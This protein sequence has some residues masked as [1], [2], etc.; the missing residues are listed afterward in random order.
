MS[1]GSKRRLSQ[2]VGLVLL[3][4]GTA[5]LIYEP[6]RMRA[7]WPSV[8]ALALV[9]LTRRA[10]LG[11]LV[12]AVVG[13]LLLAGGNPVGAVT[14]LGRDHLAP[15][16][17]SEWKLAAIAFTLILGGFAG[18][19]ERGGGLEGL[20]NGA[21]RRARDPAR[22]L[23]GG[24]MGLGLVCFFDGLANSL[25]VGRLS[26]QFAA[27]CGVSRVK[28]AYLTDSTSS[29]VACVA[30]VS[31]WIAYQ[32]SMIREGFGQIGQEV[33]PYLYF[34][35]SIPYNTYC[36]LTLLL[37]GLM[38][39]RRYHP[40]PMAEYERAARQEASQKVPD[41]GAEQNEKG[42]VALWRALVPLAVLLLTLLFGFYV[43]GLRW[44]AE[45]GADRPS[46]FP[47]TAEK[48]ATAFGSNAGPFVM[49]FAGIVATLLALALFP[50]GQGRGNGVLAFLS[51]VKNMLGPV[52]ILI[53]AWM[54]GSTLSAL[55][56]GDLVSR[57]A[58]EHVPVFLLPLLIFIC[59]ALISFS[60]GTSWGTMGILM[61]MAIPMVAGYTGL[62][63]GT[64]E[65]MY[66]AVIGAV[67][68][69]AVFGDHCSPI[70]DT[71][72]VSSIAC[73]VEPADHVRTQMPYAL[74]AAAVSAV[75]GFLSAG[76]GLPGWAGLAS[77]AVLLSAF[78]IWRTRG[79]VLSD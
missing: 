73:G 33:N 41:A 34:V 11:L 20:V 62:D 39:W 7:L 51:G 15:H 52:C 58:S 26:R 74:L 48:I 67:F 78:V 79:K 70:S 19:I 27:R 3:V 60:T 17:E 30:F 32:L 69:G 14:S 31:T 40:G 44:D 21:L 71:T 10:M 29:A 24:V 55:G 47:V 22:G 43:F 8:V 28:I 56:A 46:F 23:Q 38:I 18:V 35:R 61:P 16:F 37:L 76:L 5:I 68:S 36:W 65:V 1:E 63:A 13:A 45:P 50:Y 64:Q 25:L 54:L 57:L 4:L 42:S 49:C 9:F 2:G 12:G 66:A 77:G 59:G 75:A 6:L 72:I 53:A